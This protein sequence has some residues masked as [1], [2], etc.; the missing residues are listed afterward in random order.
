MRCFPL[1]RDEGLVD[2]IDVFCENIGFSLM[3]SEQVFERA[4]QLGL[5]VKMHAEQLSNSGGAK[6]AARYHALSADHLEHLD[7]AGV[8]AMKEEGVV[9]VL[10]PGAFYF[11]R[12]TQL[13]PVDCLRRHKVPIAL[14]TD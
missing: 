9:A 3:Q 11:L 6:L 2:A 5:P 12:D 4:A 7:E 14:A 13:P 10:L 1:W 8:L